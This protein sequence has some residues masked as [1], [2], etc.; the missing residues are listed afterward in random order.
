MDTTRLIDLVIVFS[1]A[2]VVGTVV[3]YLVP[4]RIKHGLMLVP[5]FAVVFALLVWEISVWAG[6]PAEFGQL[7]WLI[8]LVL[9]AG[10]TVAFALVLVR[11]RTVADDDMLAT[12]LAG[13]RTL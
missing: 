6:L 8:L 10:V 12:A 7:A 2:L 3:R 1:S 13:I 4:G 9:T 11:R 5:A